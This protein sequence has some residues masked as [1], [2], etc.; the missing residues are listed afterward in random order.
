M[1]SKAI[2]LIA[3]LACI[4]HNLSAQEW[5]GQGTQFNAESILR[6]QVVLPSSPEAA[7]LGKFGH[8]PISPFTGSPQINIPLYQLNGRYLPWSVSLSY[9]VHAVKVDEVPSWTGLGWTLNGP[10]VITRSVV[11]DPDPNPA[12]GVLT[13][14]LYDCTIKVGQIMIRKVPLFAKS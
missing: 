3:F 7:S 9:D 12:P 11:G 8:I 10:G 13:V 6:N 2:L 14:R 4:T 5:D 1:R